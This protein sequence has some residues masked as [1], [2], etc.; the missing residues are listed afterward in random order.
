MNKNIVEKSRK[1]YLEYEKRHQEILDAAIRLFNARGYVAATTAEI[2]REA[3]ISEPTM[4]RH[5]ENKKDLFFAC[6][7]SITEEL[8]SDYREV[9]KST[10]GDERGYLRGVVKVYLDFVAKNPHKSNFLV[11]L[12]SYRNDPEFNI[13]FT[14]FMEK[15]IEGVRRVLES[16]KK[17]GILKSKI[18]IPILAGMFVNQYFTVVSMKEFVELADI[19]EEL[20]Y[21]LMKNMLVME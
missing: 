1:K 17:K 8:L 21:E 19:T 18:D 14:D 6:F 12:L 2:A 3:D 20:F 9:Y 15:C 5:F 11:H 13:I 16:A 10:L 7:E 4:Y